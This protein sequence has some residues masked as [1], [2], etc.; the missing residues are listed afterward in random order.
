MDRA[1]PG[2]G[3]RRIRSGGFEMERRDFITALGGATALMTT[4]LTAAAPALAQDADHAHRHGHDHPPQFAALAMSSAHCVSTGNDCLRHCFGML[5]MNDT[6]MVA[7]LRSIHDLVAACAALESLAATDSPHT[8]VLAKA[9]GEI[10]TACAAE[11]GK[12]P[13]IA[14]CRSCQESCLA[15]AAECKKIAA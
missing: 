6:S 2:R 12:F 14:A 11:C 13:A 9:V 15:C 4:A 10:C 1:P 8:R 7:C 3:P 5:A